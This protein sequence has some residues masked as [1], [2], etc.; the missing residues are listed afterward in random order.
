MLCKS[1]SCHEATVFENAIQKRTLPKSN[2][3][4]EC[5]AKANAAIKQQCAASSTPGF[6]TMDGLCG[7][8]VFG[9]VQFISEV[10]GFW[11]VQKCTFANVS[12]PLGGGGKTVL[13]QH[14]RNPNPRGLGTRL[15]KLRVVC[16]VIG[17]TN[18][19]T[20]ENGRSWN[21]GH[22]GWGYPR[23]HGT[24]RQVRQV[25]SRTNSRSGG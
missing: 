12:R 10:N 9:V 19:H 23:R 22:R 6:G 14:L 13:I 20:N 25:R 7:C 18:T 8:G 11:W 17:L 4:R 1:E 24:H 21:R 2:S 16:P 15:F 3:V 5:Y